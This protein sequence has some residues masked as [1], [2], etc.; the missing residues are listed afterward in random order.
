MRMLMAEGFGSSRLAQTAAPLA[1]GP[2]GLRF[3]PTAGPAGCIS[4]RLTMPLMRY[5]MPI[6]IVD[7][8]IP[9]TMT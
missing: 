3:A 4:V 8:G 1:T 9:F 6:P 5:P 7:H 2:G